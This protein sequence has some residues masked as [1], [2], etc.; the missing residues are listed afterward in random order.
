MQSNIDSEG[1]DKH[2]GYTKDDSGTVW[3]W[4]YDGDELSFTDR[5]VPTDHPIYTEDVPD[6]VREHARQ[7][8]KQ[9][10]DN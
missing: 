4:D 8:A 5:G 2:H 9:Y 6:D 3:Y 1:T 7:Y 10:V